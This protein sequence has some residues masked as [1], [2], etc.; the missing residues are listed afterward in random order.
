MTVG[1]PRT[2]TP[3]CTVRVTSDAGTSLE[4]QL[5]PRHP[6]LSSAGRPAPGTSE[7][8]PAGHVFVH[9]YRVTGTLV[10][11]RAIFGPT[12]NIERQRL[13]KH[14]ARVVFAGGRLTGF[15]AADDEVK[16]A[17]DTYLASHVNDPPYPRP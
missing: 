13:R 11:D 16:A 14:P 5:D 10:V 12:A 15:E 17:I 2:I 6:V 1:R 8:L 4:V 9:P 7:N 3:P